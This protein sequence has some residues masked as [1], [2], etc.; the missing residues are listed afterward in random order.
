MTILNGWKEIGLYLRRTPKSAQRWERLGLPARRISKSK[1]SP[2]IAYCEEIDQW[3][4]RNGSHETSDQGKRT[5]FRRFTEL[6]PVVVDPDL[7]HLAERVKLMM[8]LHAQHVKL[9]TEL[10]TQ[11]RD[12]RIETRLARQRLCKT[13]SE[14]LNLTRPS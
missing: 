6:D 10:S 8:E 4:R 9:M 11:S 2:V 3:L 14:S 5:P 7:R 12:L 13:V 1:R